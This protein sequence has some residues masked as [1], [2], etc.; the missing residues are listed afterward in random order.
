M[1]MTAKVKGI[2]FDKDGTL[3][4]FNATWAVWAYDFLTDLVG[5]DAPKAA[6]LGGALGFDYA[7][8]TF[9]PE[10][11]VIAGTAEEVA[12]YIKPFVPDVPDAELLDRMNAAAA[13]A[14][15]VEAVPLAPL[16]A[17]LRARGLKL[18]V[19]TNDAEHPARAHLVKA[20]VLEEFDFVAGFDSGFGGKPQ[21]GQLLAFAD[22]HGLDPSEVVMI[23]DSLHDLHAGRAAGMRCIGVLTGM[24]SGP[25]L[26]P[27]AD[28][29]LP[30]IGFLPD[31]L[32]QQDLWP[33]LETQR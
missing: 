21:P 4:D 12:S 30:D 10:S 22:Q 13:V 18:G 5:G 11:P 3:F 31:W 19:A 23:G 6:F 2:L 17:E 20:G 14:P 25:D 27:H 33:E 28:V 29:V 16:L 32:T 7:H 8:R 26:S 1:D 24:A 9:H 15:Q